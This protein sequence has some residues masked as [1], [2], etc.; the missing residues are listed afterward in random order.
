VTDIVLRATE[1]VREYRRN[2]GLFRA[3]PAALRA[4]DGVSLSVPRGRTLGVVGES[5][6]GK[7]TLARMM[8]GLLEPTAG[9]LEIDGESIAS[10]AKRDRRSLHR[11]VQMVFQDPLGSLNPRKTVRQILSAPLRALHGL[12]AARCRAR[13]GELMDLVA[14]RADFADRY[15][16]EFSGGQSQRIGIARALAAQP[17]VIVLDEPVSA[18]DVSVQ[19]QVLL[20]LTDLQRRMGLTYVFISHDLAVVETIAHDVAVMQRGRIVEYAPAERIFSDPQNDYT[21]LLLSC[22]PRVGG[23]ATGRAARA[24]QEAPCPS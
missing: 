20:L 9:L 23:E 21:R 4:V 7:S 15:P 8:V 18:L 2:R 3:R 6:C 13:V 16:H 24:V 22:V 5:G 11:R 1:V 14:L 19:A 12:D 17:E 10:L